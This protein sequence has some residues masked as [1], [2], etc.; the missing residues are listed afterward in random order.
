MHKDK[1]QHPLPEKCQL[2]HAME[3][4]DS[5]KSYKQVEDMTGISKSTLIRARRSM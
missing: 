5:G 4:L 1:E 2:Q 3:L